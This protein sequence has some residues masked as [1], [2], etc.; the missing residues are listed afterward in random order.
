MVRAQVI[1]LLSIKLYNGF[2]KT[3]CAQ[4]ILHTTLKLPRP[5]S[6]RSNEKLRDVELSTTTN[7]P[8][9][10]YSSKGVIMETI[11]AQLTALGVDN[12]A[13]DDATARNV[14]K[15]LKLD[16]PNVH[17]VSIVEYTTK[18]GRTG[19]YC[20]TDAYVVGTNKNGKPDTAQG[21]FVRVEALDAIIADLQIAKGLLGKK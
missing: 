21:L 15:A 10:G 9:K 7:Y 3:A 12:S 11:R 20:K 17:E 6:S 4:I 5:V 8:E 14:A 18:G 19:L 2:L 16:V 1:Y 13:M